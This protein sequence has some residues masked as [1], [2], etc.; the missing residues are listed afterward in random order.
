M[1]Q[2]IRDKRNLEKYVQQMVELKARLSHLKENPAGK[3]DRFAIENSALHI[4]KIIE[5]FAFSLMS[6]HKEEYKRY[7][8]SSGADFLKDWNGRDILY[9]LTNLNPDM[10]FKPIEKQLKVQ[11]DGVKSVTLKD[12]KSVYTIKRLSKLYD[13]CG[14]ILHVS[15]PWKHCNKIESF[16]GELPSITQKLLSTFEDQTIMVNHWDSGESTVV[17]VTLTGVNSSPSYHLALGAGNFGF[18]TV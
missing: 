14:G 6:L 18:G 3:G 7:R 12:E 8:Q 16:S 1:K 5:L 4:R 10:F 15:N 11:P 17:I 9:N 13:R 2:E